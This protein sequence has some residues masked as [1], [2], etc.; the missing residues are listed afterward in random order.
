MKT[1]INVLINSSFDKFYFMDILYSIHLLLCFRYEI[2]NSFYILMS[3]GVKSKY[4]QYYTDY[5]S[6]QKSR[7]QLFYL[8]N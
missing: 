4:F 2:F 6:L 3:D 7:V 8:L 5:R 1:N